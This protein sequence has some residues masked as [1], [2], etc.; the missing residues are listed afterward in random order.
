MYSNGL[1]LQDIRNTA[2][3]LADNK[4]YAVLLIDEM[5]VREDLVY[6]R[7]GGEI[8]G[9]ISPETWNFKKVNIFEDL[10]L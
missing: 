9:F 4:K 3:G 5:S 6:D 2:N 7:R 8:V 10:Y 1:F